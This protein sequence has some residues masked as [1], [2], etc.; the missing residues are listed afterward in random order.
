MHSV[1]LK[2][3]FD[4]NNPHKE[5]RMSQE[6]MVPMVHLNGTSKKEL[7]SQYDNAIQALE[8]ALDVVLKSAPN[9]R[10]YYPKGLNAYEVAREQH[11]ERISRINDVI[12]ELTSIV[13]EIA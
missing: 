9:G 2:Q 13:E 4:N 6:I 1:L 11:Y 5:K 10:D 8:T 3:G 7:V 12:N